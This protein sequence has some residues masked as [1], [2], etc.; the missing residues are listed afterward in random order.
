DDVH[1]VLDLAVNDV[2]HRLGQPPVVLLLVGGTGVAPALD[3]LV[4]GAGTGQVARVRNKD[5]IRAVPHETTSALSR[6]GLSSRRRHVSPR[7]TLLAIRHNNGSAG[8][9][10]RS[11]RN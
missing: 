2:L 5:A 9:R 7:F 1:A 6:S 10:A 3:Q 8:A 11:V 4:E